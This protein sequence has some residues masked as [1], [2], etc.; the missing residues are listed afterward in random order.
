MGSGAEMVDMRDNEFSGVINIRT[1]RGFESLKE[2]VASIAEEVAKSKT[3][4]ELPCGFGG[5]GGGFPGGGG[6]VDFILDYTSVD[7]EWKSPITER[8]KALREEADRLENELISK[9]R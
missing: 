5:G 7:C 3:F 4:V 6:G 2:L 8:I 1:T 9:E